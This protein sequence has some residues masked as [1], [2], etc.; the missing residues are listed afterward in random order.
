M[1]NGHSHEHQSAS[2]SLGEDI[3]FRAIGAG[4]IYSGKSFPNQYE[5]LQIDVANGSLKIW[6]RIWSGAMRWCANASWRDLDNDESWKGALP[7]EVVV[8][9]PQNQT[10]PIA[11][12]Q[13]LMKP[14]CI[15]QRQLSFTDFPEVLNET[16][17]NNTINLA[18]IVGSGRYYESDHVS[19]GTDC[20]GIP[21]IVSSLKERLPKINATSHLDIDI[22]GTPTLQNS[23]L[24]LIGSGKVNYVTKMLMEHFQGS[25]QFKFMPFSAIISNVGPNTIYRDGDNN[26]RGLGVLCLQ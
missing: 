16:I 14:Y 4:C 23:N 22:F 13:K 19:F 17:E 9:P 2:I 20:L 11:T 12:S 5:I 24:L 26:D 7:G 18:V 10:P 25:L 3:D 21:E 1:L 6:P 8:P 15:N